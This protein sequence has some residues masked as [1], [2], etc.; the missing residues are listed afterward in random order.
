M[1]AYGTI[2]MFRAHSL[3][4][5]YI[6]FGVIGSELACRGHKAGDRPK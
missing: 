5:S 2:D 4:V 3:I 1:V 6:K